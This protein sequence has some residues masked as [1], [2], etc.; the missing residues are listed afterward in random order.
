MVNRANNYIRVIRESK[1]ISRA[2]L[3]K[4]TGVSIRTLE[5]WESGKRHPSNMENLKKV[6]KA[7]D[8]K[9]EDLI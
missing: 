3:A 7:L 2:E 5:D 1:G 9:I 6:A 4:M 8:V